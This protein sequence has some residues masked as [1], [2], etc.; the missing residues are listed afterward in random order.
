MTTV[1]V[2]RLSFLVVFPKHL[3]P[4]PIIHNMQ[5]YR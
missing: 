4:K 2:R 3:F 5:G 1:A